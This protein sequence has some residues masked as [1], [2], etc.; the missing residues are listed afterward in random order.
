MTNRERS[1]EERP[2]SDAQVARDEQVCDLRS[3]FSG[4]DV[5]EHFALF[6]DSRELQ[7]LTAAA[8]IQ[9]ALG[10][11]YRCL[12]LADEN[13][14]AD[15]ESVFAD[16]GIDVAGRF[17][18]GDLEI[19]DAADVY[20]A[21]GFDPDHLLGRL[22]S[23]YEQTLDDD[24]EGFCAAGENTWSFR[25]EV[26]FDAIVEFERAF[27]EW[28]SDAAVAT[29]CQYSLDRFDESAVAKAIRTHPYVLYRGTL[30]ENPYY[31]P[32]S[33]R[34]G[35]DDPETEAE[36]VLRQLRDLAHHRRRIERGR[37]RLSVV[38]R[39]LRHNIANDL[40]AVLGRLELARDA[41]DLDDETGVHV[42]NAMRIAE[43]M[44]DRADKARHVERTLSNATLEVRPLAAVLEEAVAE[45]ASAH[46]EAEIALSGPTRQTVLA[47]AHLATAVTELLTNAVVH[48]DGESV[49]VHVTVTAAPDNYVTVAVDNRGPAIPENDRRAL[50]AGG[51]SR[52]DHGS[53]LG[54]WLVK[55]IVENSRGEFRL[56]DDG[57]VDD[58]RVEIRLQTVD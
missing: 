26:S 52:L 42:S 50:R 14:I 8:F 38:N 10:N 54:L 3:E 23:A 21:D 4:V 2:P 51:E 55:W 22:E 44:A 28:A 35:A 31:V 47:D 20:L 40:S 43:R 12:Y 48:Q 19:R 1:R 17:D 41:E 49:A 58:S 15:V 34:P 30:C 33:A 56:P 6:Y 27:D 9:H 57:G 32:S 13:A 25:T 5:D 7:L 11:G 39:V 53:G 16:V 18:A 29:L 45:V 37:E 36:F 46:P 24:Y